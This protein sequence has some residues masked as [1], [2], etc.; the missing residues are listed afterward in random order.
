MNPT[1]HWESWRYKWCI[2][3]TRTFL[4][5]WHFSSAESEGDLQN[6]T[7]AA[8]TAP[9]SCASALL[10]HLW[11]YVGWGFTSFLMPPTGS[12]ICHLFPLWSG[13][14]VPL[15]HRRYQVA[16]VSSRS[17]HR[18]CWKTAQPNQR[19]KQKL[20]HFS[21]WKPCFDSQGWQGH[22]LY[23]ALLTIQSY[24]NMESS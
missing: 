13:P 1:R 8:A 12:F 20:I 4:Q 3:N 5:N 9:S 21:T 15:V 2:H 7:C 11:L 14:G 18:I 24:P 23:L 16:L 17:K 6:K 22:P 19:S 10:W